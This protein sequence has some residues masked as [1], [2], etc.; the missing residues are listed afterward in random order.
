M[1]A[2]RL[3]KMII[4]VM[5]WEYII[6]RPGTASCIA[7]RSK[8]LRHSRSTSTSEFKKK[9]KNYSNSHNYHGG[10]S[11]PKPPTHKSTPTLPKAPP[12]KSTPSSPPIPKPKVGTPSTPPPDVD[13]GGHSTIFN[14][15]DFGAKGDRDGSTDDTNVRKGLQSVQ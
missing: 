2:Y 10:G 11:K 12:H 8:H 7:R 4:G 14:V 3:G 6:P 9:G 15:L 1:H 5:L 13:N